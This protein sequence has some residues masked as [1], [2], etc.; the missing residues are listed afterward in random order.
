MTKK[1]SV[2]LLAVLVAFASATAK[3][4]DGY[5]EERHRLIQI[6]NEKDELIEEQA[7]LIAAYRSSYM[8]AHRYATEFAFAPTIAPTPEPYP[9]RHQ[10][11]VTDI[12]PEGYVDA[13]EE[14]QYEPS[15]Y[16]RTHTSGYPSAA[17]DDNCGRW[18]GFDCPVPGVERDWPA[19]IH[20][21]GWVKQA[22]RETTV[23]FMEILWTLENPTDERWDR[24][25]VAYR[26]YLDGEL[27]AEDAADER[28]YYQPPAPGET[29]EYY[30]G[31]GF[32]VFRHTVSDSLVDKLAEREH[33]T[34]LPWHW[35]LMSS[36]GEDI[37]VDEP[38]LDGG[39]LTCEVEY[40]NFRNHS[41]YD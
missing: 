7:L 24:F 33:G 40:T 37:R 8:Y 23:Y 35:W 13:G 32:P 17:A 12:C 26:I 20:H 11:T 19:Q 30:T 9:R 1:L 18:C 29:A 2:S 31:D 6:I 22:F 14:F 15:N 34:P 21:C 39:D 41:I 38:N 28:S 36:T 10:G 27:A 5:P 16:G 4:D 25:D 3:S